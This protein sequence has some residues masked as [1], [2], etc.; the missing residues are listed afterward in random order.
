MH[1]YR[2]FIYFYNSGIIVAWD[3]SRGRQFFGRPTIFEVATPV[4]YLFS[5]CFLR[6]KG[7]VGLEL[8]IAALH[9]Y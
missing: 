9:H 7:M 5:P 3:E 4:H 8:A 1:V 2:Q 6:Y